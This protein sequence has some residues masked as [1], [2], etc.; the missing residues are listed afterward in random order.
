MENNN[1]TYEYLN[2]LTKYDLIK[3]ILNNNKQLKA[4]TSTTE[5]KTNTQTKTKM[6]PFK[7]LPEEQKIA[8]YKSKG[9]EYVPYDEYMK[10]K[11]KTANVVSKSDLGLDEE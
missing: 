8:W 5:R 9:I 3:I 10:K 7:D 4:K 11:Q 6:V 2:N 1:M